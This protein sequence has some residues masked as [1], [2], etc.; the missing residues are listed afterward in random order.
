MLGFNSL[1]LFSVSKQYGLQH[2][3]SSCQSGLTVGKA[4]IQCGKE[5]ANV[6]WKS[7]KVLPRVYL[8]SRVSCPSHF[9]WDSLVK[10]WKF[11]T[12]LMTRGL[13]LTVERRQYLISKHFSNVFFLT[14][15]FQLHE[16][17]HQAPTPRYPSTLCPKETTLNYCVSF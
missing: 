3:S 6:P 7:P 17:I 15:V 8:D 2:R 10:S 13:I 14:L 4:G 12:R 5:T 9:G 16:C 1:R 11:W